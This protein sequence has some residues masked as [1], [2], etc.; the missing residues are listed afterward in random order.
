VT[1]N[2][3]SLTLRVPPA[4][5]RKGSKGLIFFAIFWNAFMIIFTLAAVGA[6]ENDA[7]QSAVPNSNFRIGVAP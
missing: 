3:D 5:I 6:G 7:G 2:A 1:D 4:G